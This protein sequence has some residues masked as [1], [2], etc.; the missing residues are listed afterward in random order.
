MDITISL[1]PKEL[2]LLH[3]NAQKRGLPA[4]E[5]AKR[6]IVE[7]LPEQTNY[8]PTLAL[9]QQWKAE[10]AAMTAEEIE[11]ENLLWAEFEKNIN[12]SRREMGMREL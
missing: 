1:S 9:F 10:D 12:A 8:D 4:T 3:A 6:L 11:A 2:S 5:F 7:Q